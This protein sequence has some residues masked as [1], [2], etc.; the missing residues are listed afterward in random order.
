[1]LSVGGGWGHLSTCQLEIVEHT[2]SQWVPI[3]KL[4]NT[5]LSLP[6][7]IL[8]FISPNPLHYM[9]ICAYRQLIK[10][11]TG[12][13]TFV[14]LISFL[15]YW[16]SYNMWVKSSS[17]LYKGLINFSCVDWN[18][19][20]IQ[21]PCPIFSS[22]TVYCCLLG[23]TNGKTSATKPIIVFILTHKQFHLN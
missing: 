23:H 6:H 16:R 20:Q 15:S 10:I 19:V 13:L 11:G 9:Y 4:D 2:Q 12:F 1:M 17:K 22:L 21:E 7:P 3:I 18:N 8:L 14:K 5:P